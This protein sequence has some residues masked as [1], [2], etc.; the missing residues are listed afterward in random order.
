M[1]TNIITSWIPITTMSIK[2]ETKQIPLLTNIPNYYYISAYKSLI[3]YSIT[4]NEE[5]Y[6]ICQKSHYHKKVHDHCL[7]S[8]LTCNSY[9]NTKV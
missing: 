9:D 2:Q 3:N 4:D 5:T 1:I 7:T 6:V 8:S